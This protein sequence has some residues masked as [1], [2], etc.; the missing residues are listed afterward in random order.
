MRSILLLGTLLCLFFLTV[1]AS[2]QSAPLS[3]KTLAEAMELQPKGATARRLAEA[4]RAWLGNDALKKGANPRIEGFT[5]AWAISGVENGAEPILRLDFG[6][7]KI[8]QMPLT[9]L[10]DTSLFVLTR[11]FPEGAGFLWSYLSGTVETNRGQIEL[12]EEHPDTKAQ[13]G[14]PKGKVIANSKWKS[15]IFAGTER[16]WWLYVPQQYTPDKPAC[17]MVF[18]DGQWY[19]NYIPPVLDNLIA[20]QEMP[21]TIGI[22]LSPGTFADGK[23]NR[24]FEYDTLS[25]QYA[26]F[27]LEE[28]LP[29]VEKTYKLR[30]DAAGRAIAGI[31][32]GG[33][34]AFT[35]AWERP[36]KFSKVLSWVGSFTNIASGASLREG[37]HNYPALIRKTEATKPIR[38]F[39]QAGRN[40]LDN[41]HGN[42]YLANK[43][44]DRSLAFKKYD[45]KFV[46]GNGFHSDRHG[47]AILPQSLRWLWRETP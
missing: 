33:I 37:G 3:P 2:A 38:V 41:L 1:I 42:W 47:R 12:F 31:S 34:C 43:Q 46:E 6:E 18:Q 4:I 19:K 23:S 25:D 22:F 17:V 40:D 5:V 30:Q 28:I 8:D 13:P 10:G 39:L 29:E 32:S 16:D 14:V 20:K 21:V 15:K 44:M 11:T 27:L 24:S 45:Y 26:R 35:V 9:R 36:D 7:G